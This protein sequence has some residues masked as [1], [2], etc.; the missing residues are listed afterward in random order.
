MSKQ[1]SNALSGALFATSDKTILSG[2][3]QFTEKKDD[4]IVSVMQLGE[5]G[6]HTFNVHKR[7][8]DGQAVGK[9]QLTVKF[10]R[11]PTAGAL[12][13]NG[14]PTPVARSIEVTGPKADESM[15]FCIWNAQRK[16]D[17]S[18]FYQV[19]PDSFEPRELPPL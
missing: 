4:T 13:K 8:K 12:N 6:V 14:Q 17:G 15:R 16:E 7:G 10:K 11:T 1:Y 18:P 3:F 9:P 5:D 2:M 19:K